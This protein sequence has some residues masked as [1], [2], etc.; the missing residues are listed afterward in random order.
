[1]RVELSNRD[2]PVSLT[3]SCTGCGLCV[4]A[5]PAEAIVVPHKPPKPELKNGAVEFGCSKLQL[6][7]SMECLGMLDAY[8]LTYFGVKAEQVRISLDSHRCEVCNPGVAAAV[9]QTVEMANTVLRKL[10]R[11]EIQLTLRRGKEDIKI[12]RRELFA[13]CFSRA[14]ETLLD[15]LPLSLH[16]DTS[17]R[18]LLI[19][20]IPAE[21][22]QSSKRDMSPLFWGGKVN[23][24]CD[25]CGICVRS[26]QQDALILTV[27]EQGGYRKLL[28]NQSKCIGCRACTLLCP[29]SALQIDNALSSIKIIASQKAVA[30]TGKKC[31]T[32]CGKVMAPEAPSLCE[33]CL[34]GRN[35]YL[36]SIY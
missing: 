28:H 17:Y 23:E 25:M 29:R 9:K 15:M 22:A 4:A 14:R 10:G 21:T 2:V 34:P 7:S 24:H 20:S 3:D 35:S 33:Q 36:Q 18:Q 16:Q 32:Q 31:C 11:Q 13:F 26:C 1:M 6:D 27:E 19:E 12:N 30:L 8:V 5:C